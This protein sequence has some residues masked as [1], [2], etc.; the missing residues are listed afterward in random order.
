MTTRCHTLHG[1][2][3]PSNPVTGDVNLMDIAHALSMT[4]RYGGAC[5]SFYS[6]A[7]HAWL[8]SD[9]VFKATGSAEA[10]LLALHHD[11]AEAYIHDLRRPIKNALIYSPNAGGK[12]AEIFSSLEDRIMVV[13]SEALLLP[14]M[15]PEWAKAIKDAD[16]A[17]LAAE[18]RYFWPGDKEAEKIQKRTPLFHLFEDP[19]KKPADSCWLFQLMH[20]SYLKQIREASCAHSSMATTEGEMP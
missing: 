6:V 4:C 14:A 18:M 17:L 13:I 19:E 15:R 1:S 5:H 3:D 8:V 7:E 10:G 9:L 2:F 12:G 11:D 20:Q 16:N